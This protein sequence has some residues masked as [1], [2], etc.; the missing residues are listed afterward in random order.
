[1]KLTKENIETLKNLHG[2]GTIDLLKKIAE[3]MINDLRMS[4]I[5]RDTAEDT[6]KNLYES[7]GGEKYLQQFFNYLHDSCNV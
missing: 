1:M 5:P 4:R 7:Y 6:L 3:D 2:T